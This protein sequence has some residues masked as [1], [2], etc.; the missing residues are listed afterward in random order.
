MSPEIIAAVFTAIWGLVSWLLRNKDKQQEKQLE[1]QDR[2]I[3]LLFGK[4][5]ED[6]KD[7]QDLRVQ[8]AGNHYQRHELDAR[9]DKLETAFKDGFK[10]LGD[11]VDRLA[12]SLIEKRAP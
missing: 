5:D 8:I 6:V 4:H 12:E 11:K 2:K 9:F 3:S 1:E 10:A 7:L